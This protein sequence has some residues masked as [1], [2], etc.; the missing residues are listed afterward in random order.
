MDL[1]FDDLKCSTNK[2]RP[3]PPK[4]QILAALRYLGS[5]SLQ[6]TV[7]DTLN[8]SQP[9]VSLCVTRV[10]NALIAKKDEFIVWPDNT[11]RT[12]AKFFEIAQ[13]PRVVG[14]I[15]GTHVRIQQP[16]EDPNAYI[17]RKYY[18]SINVCAVCDANR[19][20]TFASIRWPGS[21]HDSFVLKQTKLWDD[22]E[23]GRKQGIILD[24]N[25]YP[26]RNWLMTPVSIPRSQSEENYNTSHKRT[27]VTIECAFGML[28]KRFRILHDEM[29]VPTEK[30]LTL[31]FI[32]N[33]S[34]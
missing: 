34:P 4:V 17:I 20:F 6:A 19:K 18:P 27:R 23:T 2:G 11:S 32:G 13:F 26:C 16:R 9:T 5:A 8:L 29:R 14:A 25:G 31:I 1:L 24:D 30:V 28:K 33:D 10:C 15:D 21:C 7:V 22:F 3:I 12:Q